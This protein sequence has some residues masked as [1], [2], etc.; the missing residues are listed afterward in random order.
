ML[1]STPKRT[2]SRLSWPRILPAVMTLAFLVVGSYYA[3][4]ASKGERLTA[5]SR[6]EPARDPEAQ[7][8]QAAFEAATRTAAM[9]F[10]PS[11]EMK[12]NTDFLLT[13]A[14]LVQEVLSDD[15]IVTYPS[16]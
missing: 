12:E 11:L 14:L 4:G 10:A 16:E 5:S 1:K 7:A 3:A 15:L 9:G 6:A 2:A 8:K 13:P